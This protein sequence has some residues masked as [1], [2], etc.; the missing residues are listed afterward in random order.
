MATG[1]P[2]EL[3]QLAE[4]MARFRF[5]PFGWVMAVFP[6][7]VP[8]TPLEHEDGPDTWQLEEMQHIADSLA[9][10][11][12][13]VIRRAIASGHGIGKTTWFAWMI[14][15]AITTWPN[16]RGTVTANTDTQ[17]RTKTWPEVTKWYHMMLAPLR[18]RFEITATSIYSSEPGKDRT[19]RIDAIPWSKTNPAAFAGLHNAGSRTFIAFDEGSEIADIIYDTAE[20]ATTDADTQIIWLVA[21]NPT[22]NTGRFKEV[23]EGK[24]R[25]LWRR[26]QI[27]SRTCKRTD[28]KRLA[29]WAETWGEDSD[30]VRVR[31]R[32]MFPR[33]GS[34][35]FIPSDLV[36]GAKKRPVIY[37]PYEP[38]VA[39][40][41]IARYGDDKSVLRARRGRDARS[42]PKKEWRGIN[43]MDL[44]G[45]V[46][47]W[48][49]QN[50]PD[51]LFVDV[52]GLGVGVYDRLVQL[53][54]QNVYPVNF[55]G[56]GGNVEFNGTPNIK[57][58]NTRARIYADLRGW[59]EFGCID[60][61]MDLTS[62]LTGVQYGF[63]LDN[64]IQLE[65]K[66]DMK[67]RGLASPDDGD[68]LALTFTFPVQT[69]VPMAQHPA[70]PDPRS[71]VAQT[72]VTD[73]DYDPY[74]DLR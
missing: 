56:Q 28:K 54:V 13:E 14:L 58:A 1:T 61:D 40:L 33:A 64:A 53:K 59:L 12:H 47:L 67:A 71:I 30:F 25:H 50:K 49:T 45:E 10:D 42:I 68:A 62:D 15:W 46:A 37:M 3:T 26:R 60:D 9:D 2:D 36:E 24:F 44:A 51:A 72:G 7:G 52:G 69:R 11:P 22:Q 23:I 32:G 57:T 73:G 21:G 27:D 39:G 8:G 18:A 6:W 66:E 4:F 43:T 48:C 34:L 16:T 74:K 38:L 19:W 55:G 20:G 63:N 41:D 70:A 17:L 29:E 31:V 35:Q 5:D 65:K